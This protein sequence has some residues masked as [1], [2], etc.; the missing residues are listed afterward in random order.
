MLYNFASATW[1]ILTQTVFEWDAHRL[2]LLLL[3]LKPHGAGR[4][5]LAVNLLKQSEVDFEN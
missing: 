1:N 5:G 3:K 4:A 2:L